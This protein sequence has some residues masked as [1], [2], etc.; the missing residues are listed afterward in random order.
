MSRFSTGTADNPPLPS[1]YHQ[2]Q[3]GDV[4]V[5]KNQKGKGSRFSPGTCRH[6]RFTFPPAAIFAGT[7]LLLTL[8]IL[9]GTGFGGKGSLR[10]L[11]LVKIE[12]KTDNSLEVIEERGIIPADIAEARGDDSK[13]EKASIPQVI[14]Q[15]AKSHNV[16][17]DVYSSQ[18]SNLQ[19]EDSVVDRIKAARVRIEEAVRYGEMIIEGSSV[20]SVPISAHPNKWVVLLTTC[21]SRSNVY[22]TRQYNASF[23]DTIL[24]W[25]S[26]T[27]LPLVIV[28][29]S[30]VGF[31]HLQRYVT[32]NRIDIV[33]NNS[34]KQGGSSSKLEAESL[35]A[36]IAYMNK[37]PQGK[38]DNY[39]HVLKV[40][41]RYF[42]ADIE[43]ALNQMKSNYDFYLQIRRKREMLW[44][45]SEYFGIRKELIHNLTLSVLNENNLMEHSLWNVSH[46]YSFTLFHHGFPNDIPRGG[47][48]LVLDPL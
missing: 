35:N 43:E 17:S 5:N 44:Q 36:A 12:D 16:P 22:T 8:P 39:T 24:D 20:H 4:D 6:G 38:F 28:E 32:S 34:T 46:R 3:D 30:G 23:T 14:W 11:A 13:K 45:N 18:R 31:P 48:G 1:E 25:I 15:T 26:Q 47:D 42:L 41:G 29:S 7:A 9:F 37:H 27:S 19:S 40:T 2:G 21:V 10:S 33:I